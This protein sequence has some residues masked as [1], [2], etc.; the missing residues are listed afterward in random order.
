MPDG[1]PLATLA[2][3]IDVTW[4]IHVLTV[5][6][7]SYSRAAAAEIDVTNLGSLYY[8]DPNN[9]DHKMVVKEIDFGMIELG[10]VQC[11]FFGASTFSESH[12]GTRAAISITNMANAPG[13][14]QAY[15]TSL[16]I[17]AKAGELIS[18]SCTFKV[19][20]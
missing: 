17:N 16:S 8:G 6:S 11:E 5:T 9:T 12:I 10:E 13:G 1:F 15:L 4:G 2:T 7:V 20:G 19:S 3:G 14:T 18:G